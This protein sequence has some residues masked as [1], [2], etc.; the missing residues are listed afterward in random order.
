MPTD[1]TQ[2]PATGPPV[3]NQ[4]GITAPKVPTPRPFVAPAPVVRARKDSIVRPVTSVQQAP[5]PLADLRAGPA[6][7]PPPPGQALTPQDVP[8][9][10][11]LIETKVTNPDGSI[12]ITKGAP[13][14]QAA[15][16]QGVTGEEPSPVEGMPMASYSKIT[17]AAE[18]D[19]SGALDAKF[20]GIGARARLD[21]ER[22]LKAYG[23]YPGKGDPNAPAPPIQPFGP[24]FNPFTGE[25]TNT[26]KRPSGLAMLGMEGELERHKQE[27]ITRNQ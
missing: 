11:P 24:S 3:P 22:Q 5:R 1:P 6:P 2:Q 19:W 10:Q 14:T 7:P 16:E 8:E 13:G 21:T 27:F 20:P 18:S 25:F 17:D 15:A 12:T 9:P 23:D 26:N 4:G